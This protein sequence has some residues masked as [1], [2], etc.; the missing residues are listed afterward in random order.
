MNLSKLESISVF[1]PAFNDESTIAQLVTNALS[2]LPQIADD[3]EII[4]VNDG[5]RDGTA[6]IL[7]ELTSSTEKVR[8]ID[9]GVNR[10]YGAALKTGFEA[11][12]NDLIFYT[13]GDGQYDVRDIVSL[14]KVLDD[15]VDVVNG[16]KTNRADA[17]HRVIVGNLY[18]RMA[19]L[20]FWLPVRDVDCDFRLIRRRSMEHISL[21]S[22]SGAICVELV[23]KLSAGGSRFKE[24]PVVHYPR[25]TGKSQF[26]TFRRIASSIIDLFGLW[27]KLILLR[28]PP[29]A[30]PEMKTQIAS[31]ERR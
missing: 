11:A 8:A 22:A 17:L 24:V 14:H 2:I 7:R 4:V 10:G 13:D 18:S 1:F 15:D 6:K 3:F 19:R 26:F 12:S 5:S 28:Q 29:L 25:L 30:E 9:H 31:N 23:R 21:E 27:V 20:M 16:Y